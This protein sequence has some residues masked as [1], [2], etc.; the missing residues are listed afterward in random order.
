MTP[1]LKNRTALV[2]GGTRGIG[3]AIAQT[4]L[5]HGARV[6]VNGRRAES[7]A[8]VADALGKRATPLAFDVADSEAVRQAFLA[9][10]KEAGGLDILVNS[11]GVMRDA[12]IGMTTDELVDEALR[13]N[14]LGTF[15]CARLAARLMQPKRSGSIINISSIVGRTGI[16]GY[17]A[18]GASKA[19]VIG[20]T[21][22]LAKE[23]AHYNVRVNALAPGFIDTDLTA[24]FAPERRDRILSQ[25]RMGRA[26]KPEEV[27]G[28]ALFL[29]SNLASYVTGQVLGVDGAMVA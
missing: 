22:S 4:F 9:L 20:L 24:G 11:A 7:T 29:A 13:V 21:V 6:F 16:E 10:R 19:A 18:Y 26:G 14:Y 3:R 8:K 23:L 17:T 27:A 15:A 25:I 1:L 2:T 5:A 28:A 12:L